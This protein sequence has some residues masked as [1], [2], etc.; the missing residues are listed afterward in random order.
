MLVRARLRMS[1]AFTRSMRSSSVVP[2]TLRRKQRTLSD[3]AL[4]TQR[5]DLRERI[6][7]AAARGAGRGGDE[8][9]LATGARV[10]V[11]RRFER[12][13]AQAVAI[14]NGKHAHLIRPEAEDS[15]RA[16]DR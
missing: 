6:Y 13:D 9:R 15:R 16:R 10:G 5:R 14:V 2:R 7:R 8:Q 4:A 11:H 3:S 12:V 1:S